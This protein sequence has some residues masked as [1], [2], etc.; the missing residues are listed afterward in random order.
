LRQ[1]T[2]GRILMSSCFIT[3]FNREAF[4]NKIVKNVLKGTVSAVPFSFNH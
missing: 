1:W 3:I 2:Y 4:N